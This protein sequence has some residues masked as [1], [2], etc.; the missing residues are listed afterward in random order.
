MTQQPDSQ[1]KGLAYMNEWQKL[2]MHVG[3]SLFGSMLVAYGTFSRV[4]ER[5]ESHTRELAE[6]RVTQNA[7]QSEITAMK[8]AQATSAEKLDNIEKGV[9]DIAQRLDKVL[10]K[11]P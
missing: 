6:V 3:I 5:V 1:K 8:V 2:L 11:R 7:Q 4:V 9:R 10:E